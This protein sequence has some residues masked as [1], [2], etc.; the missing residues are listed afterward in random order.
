MKIKKLEYE[1]DGELTV[2]QLLHR[3][4][5]DVNPTIHDKLVKDGQPI[6][7]TNVLINGKSFWHLNLL[8]TP[9]HN[10]DKVQIFP[11]AAGG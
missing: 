10:G 9:L 8:D 4:S 3:L 1:S 2:G 6:K 5:L 11:P 7:G